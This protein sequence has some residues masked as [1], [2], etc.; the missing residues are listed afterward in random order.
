MQFVSDYMR[1]ID[2]IA[3]AALVV[4]AEGPYGS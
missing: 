1:A 4:I 2:F 3:F